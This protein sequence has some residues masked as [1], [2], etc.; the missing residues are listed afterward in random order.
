MSDAERARRERQRTAS[1]INQVAERHHVCRDTLYK[2]I[3]RGRLRA[4]KL[5][6][7][8]LIY[9]DD[10]DAWVNSL[11]VLGAMSA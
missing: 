5:G 6:R 11:P 3:R 9:S 7:R 1:T 2:E 8:T 4:K 10:E